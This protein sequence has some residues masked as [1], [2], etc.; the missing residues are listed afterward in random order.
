MR[1]MFANMYR[2]Q[3]VIY[4]QVIVLVSELAKMYMIYGV[5][6]FM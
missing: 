3:C 5:R 1:Y 6:Y 2:G 4:S